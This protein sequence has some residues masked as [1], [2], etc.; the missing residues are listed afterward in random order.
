M[1]NPE[2]HAAKPRLFEISVLVNYSTV[3]LATS[4]EEA[5]KEIESW[6]QCWPNYSDFTAVSD[7][8]VVDEREGGEDDAHC[9]TS[10]AKSLL[11]ECDDE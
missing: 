10:K 5:L 1:L 9:V 4:R 3:I 6:E 11:K 2:T 8:E 7:V